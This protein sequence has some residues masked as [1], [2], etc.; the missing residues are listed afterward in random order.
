MSEYLE[1]GYVESGYI[2]SDIL[3][4]NTDTCDLT[5]LVS[6]F[7]EIDLSIASLD[8]K[9]DYLVVQINTLLSAVGSLSSTVQTVLPTKTDLQN[10]HIDTSTLA[11]KTD[12]QNLSNDIEHI[13]LPSLNGNGSEY[14]DGTQVKVSGRDVVYTVERSYHSL[15]S[16]N[17]YTVHYDL[18]SSDGYRCTVP[19]ALLTKYTSGV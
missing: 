16:D 9:V 17:G 12:L 19:E 1:N 13:V 4:Q 11:T 5:S 14:K 15:Y 3:S 18:V 7:N 2:D 6:E 10:L 8:D